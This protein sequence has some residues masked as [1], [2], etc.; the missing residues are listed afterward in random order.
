MALPLLTRK[1][2]KRAPRNKPT[3][4]WLHGFMGLLLLYPA[5]ERESGTVHIGGVLPYLQS[6]RRRIWMSQP[7]LDACSKEATFHRACIISKRGRF[8]WALIPG[9]ALSFKI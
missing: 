1:T 6:A 2:N 9:P 7:C 3:A 4:S 5:L 8:G